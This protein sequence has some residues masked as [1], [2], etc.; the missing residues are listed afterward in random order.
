MIL[1]AVSL[2]KAA[3]ML[4]IRRHENDE[5]VLALNVAMYD[6]MSVMGLYGDNDSTFANPLT[7]VCRLQQ[8]SNPRHQGLDGQT[9]EERLLGRMDDIIESITR[10]AKLCD[11][12]QKRRI[13]GWNLLYSSSF[14]DA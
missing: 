5:K 7:G 12:Y 10:C 9:V 13:A 3:V 11:S 14:V 6:M 1:V 4:E 2:F 8:I